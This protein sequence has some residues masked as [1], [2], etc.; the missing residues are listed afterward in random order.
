MKKRLIIFLL[1]F[2]ILSVKASS[3][4]IDFQ[5][6]YDNKTGFSGVASS[7]F[8]G[9]YEE[10]EFN[11]EF[12]NYIKNMNKHFKPVLQ[13]T[14]KDRW[15]IDKALSEWMY[16]ENERYVVVI[17]DNMNSEN[18]IFAFV[19]C[20]QLHYLVSNAWYCNFNKMKEFKKLFNK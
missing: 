19:E 16:D 17:S 2:I 15:L 9:V 1:F 5:K 3:Q 12:N 6:Y 20:D 13:F 7:T 8:L 18:F 11:K 10:E 14:K 4:S